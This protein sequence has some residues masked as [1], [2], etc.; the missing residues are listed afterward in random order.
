[1]GCLGQSG[2]LLAIVE[3]GIGD[4][5]GETGCAI[6]AVPGG[7]SGWTGVSLENDIRSHRAP[8]WVS[9]FW[10]RSGGTGICKKVNK[11]TWLLFIG[12]KAND[13]GG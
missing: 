9:W 10:S 6:E 11:V 1:M 5:D 2:Y 8:A 7:K 4:F 3:D 13:A 12:S